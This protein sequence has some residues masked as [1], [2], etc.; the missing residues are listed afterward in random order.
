MHKLQLIF[1]HDA[2]AQKMAKSWPFMDQFSPNHH[3]IFYLVHKNYSVKSKQKN[4]ETRS[5][6][7]DAHAP[8]TAEIWHENGRISAVYG[9][10]SSKPPQNVLF[11]P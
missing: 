5:K 3:R 6:S 2:H 10:I 7:H 1:Y 9:P 4:E 11:G 8:K